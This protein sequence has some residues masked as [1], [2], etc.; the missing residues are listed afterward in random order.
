MI[1]DKGQ[2][3]P[4][5]KTVLILGVSSLLGSSMAEFLKNDYKVVGT[6]FK[7]K[8]TI[9]GI[10]TLPCDVLDKD[11]VQ[12]MIYAFK[13]DITLYCV[14]VASVYACS[15]SEEMADALNA[16]G[17]FNVAESCGRYRSQIIYFSSNFVFSGE[18]KNYMEMDIPDAN[19]SLGKTQASSEFFIQ[20]TSL[21]YLA[22]RCCRIYG[23]GIDPLKRGWF[24]TLQNKL[25]SREK[26]ACDDFVNVG[27][28]DVYYLAMVV[29]IAIERGV[30]NRLFQVS[31]SDQ[32][33]YY[34]F[35]KLYCQIFKESDDFISK[36]KWP[37]PVLASQAMNTPVGDFLRYK[38]DIA[39]I[40]GYLNIEM[41]TVEESLRYS[42]HRLGGSDDHKGKVK[43]GDGVSFI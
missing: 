17:L 20:K 36:T 21:N 30:T 19:T 8:V 31:S 13:P 24:Y 1:K 9:P 35:A 12:L 18:N 37:F 38:M 15:K 4:Q 14:G 7:C 10:L 39:N 2:I 3:L 22:F 40:E 32:M 42:F 41:P 27:F 26:F 5:K 16:S 33:S 11:Q 28:L 29:K 6:Y 25:L 43:K 23:R 34:D